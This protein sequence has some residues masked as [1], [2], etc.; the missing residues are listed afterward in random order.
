M[1]NA[2]TTTATLLGTDAPVATE[3]C[4]LVDKDHFVELHVS[5][6]NRLYADRT[7][8]WNLVNGV[9][10]AI[11]GEGWSD[12]RGYSVRAGRDHIVVTMPATTTR[13]GVIFALTREQA[14]AFGN[15]CVES[16]QRNV[17]VDIA[18]V[19]ARWGDEP[20]SPVVRARIA[21]RLLRAA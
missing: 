2:N 21:E 16:A 1:R 7:I 12:Q 18:T 14:V 9:I 11:G 19:D 13:H 15:A 8:S 17:H 10:G 20:T 5:G 6:A 4:V 3:L